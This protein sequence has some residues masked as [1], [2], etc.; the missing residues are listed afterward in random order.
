M[1]MISFDHFYM[2]SVGQQSYH[3]HNL[4]FE[5]SNQFNNNWINNVMSINSR[6]QPLN[7]AWDQY[8]SLVSLLLIY[9]HQA[10][11]ADNC[12]IILSLIEEWVSVNWNTAV[13]VKILE[14]SQAHCINTH[15][16]LYFLLF[17]HPR[18]HLSIMVCYHVLDSRRMSG[19]KIKHYCSC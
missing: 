1:D 10:T 17:I 13:N 9:T 4:D 2:S 12:C 19:W 6:T 8:G 5:L 18:Q 16:L 14:Q 7:C 3:D 15:L 11:S